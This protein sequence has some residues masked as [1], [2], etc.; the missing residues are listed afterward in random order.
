MDLEARAKAAALGLEGPM[1]VGPGL[2]KSVHHTAV[3]AERTEVFDT[4]L[5]WLKVAGDSIHYWPEQGI[6]ALEDT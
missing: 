5:E 4:V 3:A 1:Q 2:G 6:V